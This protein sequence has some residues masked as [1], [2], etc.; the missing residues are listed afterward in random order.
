[1]IFLYLLPMLLILIGIGIC[2]SAVARPE[3]FP[4]GIRGV[5][6][7]VETVHFQSLEAEIIEQ[8]L[9]QDPDGVLRLSKLEQRHIQRKRLQ[10][11]THQVKAMKCNVKLYRS[12]ACWELVQPVDKSSGQESVRTRMAEVILQIAPRCLLA[13]T[14]LEFHIKVAAVFSYIHPSNQTLGHP[15]L[16]MLEFATRKYADMTSYALSVAH[17]YGRIH[18][19]N[20]MSAL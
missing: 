14:V 19:E 20:L 2:V 7:Y 15:L 10:W 11:L 16:F 17:S 12:A 1:M 4:E 18:Y 6:A 5:T 3:P 9:K 13:V 8:R